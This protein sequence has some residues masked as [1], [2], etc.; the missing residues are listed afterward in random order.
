[1][2][3]PAL[4]VDMKK[5]VVIC[6]GGFGKEMLDYLSD[7]FS[8]DSGYEFERIQDLFPDDKLIVKPDEVFVVPNGDP[9]V[10]AR[11]VKKIE[12]AGGQLLSVIHPTCYVA[13]TATIGLGVIMCP[14]AYVGPGAVLAPHVTMNVHCGCGHNARIGS[15]SVLSP[16]AA[17]AGAAELGEGVFLGSYAF[18]APEKH[19]GNHSKLSAGTIT[20]NDVPENALAVGNPARIIANYYS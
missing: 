3:G 15:Y 7:T 9:A 17:V 4:K 19:V 2:L 20:H 13:K 11:L 5:I 8:A 18:V 1:M 10:K 16:Y 12:Q 14:F 6:K